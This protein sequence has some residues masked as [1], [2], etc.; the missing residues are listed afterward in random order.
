MHLDKHGYVSIVELIVFI[1]CIPLGIAVCL[2]H[3][4]K[5]TS[6]WIF[7]VILSV[8]RTAGAV[9]QLLTY[10]HPTEGLIKATLI[11]DSIGIAPLMLTVLGVLARLIQWINTSMQ[12]PRINS[13]FLRIIQ[14]V[15]GI[16]LILGIL[17][18][19]SPKSQAANG[20]FTPPAISKIGIL[21]NILV[22]IVLTIIFV[23][24]LPHGSA[25]PT[26]ERSLRIYIPVAL[27]AI[28]V[29]LLYATLCIFV[30]NTTFSLF[31]GSVTANVLMAIVEEFFVVI[32]T[33]AL[34]FKLE[35][36]SEEVERVVVELNQKDA[37]S[38][39]QLSQSI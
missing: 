4:F 7:V 30:H 38:G 8:I 16:S 5:R 2:R 9:C 14:L 24:S 21:L 23:L 37:G 22:F 10:D 31:N 32:I 27:A 13:K 19:T 28:F 6:G 17:G 12:N 15:I 1:P 34:G 39:G 25:L 11:L 18:V 35:R 3:G 20:T 26:S 29:R 33:I 36:V